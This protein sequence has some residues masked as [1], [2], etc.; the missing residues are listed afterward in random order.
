MQQVLAATW[1]EAIV[2]RRQFAAVPVDGV[3]LTADMPYLQYTA[4]AWLIATSKHWSLPCNGMTSRNGVLGDCQEWRR[5]QDVGRLD[6]TWHRKK[7]H[8]DRYL[9]FSS[10]HLMSQK[11]V[12]ARTP[13]LETEML[14]SDLMDKDAGGAPCQSGSGRQ[15]IPETY[16][17]TVSASVVL[18]SSRWSGCHQPPSSY[19]CWGLTANDWPY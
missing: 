1:D 7:T 10:H 12:L 9:H 19:S 4:L 8:A 13:L 3:R 5:V 11:C 14:C 17:P 16:H 2:G 6:E 18:L 15:L